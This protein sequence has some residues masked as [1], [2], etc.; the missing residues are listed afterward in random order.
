[1]A[2][3]H[4]ERLMNGEGAPLWSLPQSHEWSQP[5]TS[6]WHITVYLEMFQR[7]NFGDLVANYKFA[8]KTFADCLFCPT[9]GPTHQIAQYLEMLTFSP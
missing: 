9:N 2:L 3:K 6:Q 4:A 5:S 7:E 8:E 1:M